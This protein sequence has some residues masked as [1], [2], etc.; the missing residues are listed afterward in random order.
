MYA[1]RANLVE[2]GWWSPSLFV[3]EPLS[4]I[5]LEWLHPNVWQDVIPHWSM[6]YSCPSHKL[7]Q[8]HQLRMVTAFIRG[9]STRGTPRAIN[10]SA[11]FWVRLKLTNSTNKWCEAY[12]HTFHDCKALGRGWEPKVHVQVVA[13]I[14][15][16][17]AMYWWSDTKSSH[18]LGIW[19]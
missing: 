19:H 5:S 4:S 16:I 17:H 9:S 13:H 1:K 18:V 3:W 7:C 15:T 2:D 14:V 10:P 8:S 11:Q 6:A 12:Q